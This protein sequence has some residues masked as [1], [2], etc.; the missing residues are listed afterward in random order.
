MKAF[1]SAMMAL[2]VISVVA[3]FGLN[4]LPFTAADATS[5]DSVRLS[6]D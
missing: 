6:S 5:S 4:S 1:I 3:Y 2:V